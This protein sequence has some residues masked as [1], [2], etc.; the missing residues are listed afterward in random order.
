[1]SCQLLGAIMKLIP[2]QYHVLSFRID[3][4]NHSKNKN[5]NGNKMFLN[6]L[7]KHYIQA[8]L[9]SP[10]TPDG[11]GVCSSY[12]AA[13]AAGSPWLYSF[14]TSKKYSELKDEWP[15]RTMYFS[16]VLARND[17]PPL[18]Q[19]T[20]ILIH[21]LGYRLSIRANRIEIRFAAEEEPT[22]KKGHFSLF[23]L[24]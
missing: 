4:N 1:M 12:F 2:P 14:I 3:Q 8:E 23:L 11:G 9:W 7:N 19:H 15:K 10:V 17:L 6:I 18:L 20:I 24:Y 13:M 16:Y 5:K 21:A 22:L